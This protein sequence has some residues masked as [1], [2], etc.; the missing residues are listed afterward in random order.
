[1]LNHKKKNFIFHIPHSS[2]LIPNELRGQFL[3]SNDDLQKEIDRMTDW[4]TSELFSK[5]SEDFGFALEFPL[6]RLVVDPERFDNDKEE[7]MSSVGMG[8]IYSNTSSGEQLRD[9][10][11][12]TKEN[13]AFLLE[14]Y[15][16]PHH[17]SLE[18]AVEAQLNRFKKI[19]I[20]DCHSFPEKSLPYEIDKSSSRPEICIGTDEFHTPECLKNELNNKFMDLGYKTK[21]NSPFAGSIV[22]MKFYKKNENVHSIMIEIRRDLYINEITTKKNKNFNNVQNDLYIILSRL[23]ER[24]YDEL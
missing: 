2:T 14:R 17:Q 20:I 7:P 1:M 4:Y 10:S 11:S 22:P 13:R 21:I 18:Q 9:A 19:L 6:S 8:V 16:Y 3:L 24:Y 23:F 12:L 15:Y 5:A